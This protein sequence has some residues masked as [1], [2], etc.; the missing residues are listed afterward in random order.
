[1][2]PQ[3][4]WERLLDAYADDDWASVDEHASAL[5]DW[6]EK[7]GFPPQTV[8]HRHLRPPVNHLIAAAT[9]RLALE[10]SARGGAA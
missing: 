8:G 4:V 6:L 3:I 5:L 1:M 2:D 9:C 7:G 10:H